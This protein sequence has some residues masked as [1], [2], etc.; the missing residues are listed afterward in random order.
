ME[1]RLGCHRPERQMVPDRLRRA[2]PV[3][4]VEFLQGIGLHGLFDRAGGPR[5]FRPA[6]L[7]FPGLGAKRPAV[8]AAGRRA[9]A[10]LPQDFRYQA[11]TIIRHR[12]PDRGRCQS[13]ASR[14]RP[15]HLPVD[16][17][18]RNS[19]KPTISTMS[20]RHNR[21]RE[22]PIWRASIIRTIAC[23][24]ASA[25]TIRVRPSTRRGSANS[26]TRSA[27]CGIPSFSRI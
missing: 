10:R 13:D 3:P 24:R 6:G 18:A 12:R 19:T 5:L 4:V 23:C 20:A 14:A 21:R 11:G 2:G 15:R 1:V 17:H 8:A 27:K 9:R 25:A 16:R 22:R 7:L 26:S